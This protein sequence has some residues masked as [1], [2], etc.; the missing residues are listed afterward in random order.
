M[1][2]EEFYCL[3]HEKYIFAYLQ[4]VSRS[5]VS[6]DMAQKALHRISKLLGYSDRTSYLKCHLAYL[7]HNW[8]HVD[9]VN[10]T[11]EE[12]P[13]QLLGYD[14]RQQFLRFVCRLPNV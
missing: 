4:M 5:S 12:F 6:L 3:F 11:I 10:S 14:T 2:E 1:L 13:H 8:L 7:V 9:M